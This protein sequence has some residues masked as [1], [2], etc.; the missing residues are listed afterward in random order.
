MACSKKNQIFP[1]F[2]KIRKPHTKKW[3]EGRKA[4]EAPTTGRFREAKFAS[5]LES[6]T[7]LKRVKMNFMAGKVFF[8]LT[9]LRCARLLDAPVR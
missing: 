9:L 4:R 2:G 3:T 8:I 5:V 1:L 6:S 7:T